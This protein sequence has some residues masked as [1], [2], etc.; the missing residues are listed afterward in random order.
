MKPLHQ[1]M[2]RGLLL[3]GLALGINNISLA[4]NL[5]SNLALTGPGAGADGSGFSNTKTVRDGNINTVSQASGT[6]NQ[7]VSVKWSD[8]QTF[9]TVVL[10]EAGNRVTSWQ[11]RN[12]ETDEVIST[13]NAIG[14]SRV[15]NGSNTSFL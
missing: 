2:V 14:A 10:R 1:S 8:A 6:S 4:Q 13:G 3:A 11:L 12:H 9:N 5:G 15:I 7:R